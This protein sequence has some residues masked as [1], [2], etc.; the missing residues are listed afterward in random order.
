MTTNQERKDRK[1]ESILHMIAAG[2]T[3]AATIFA[4]VMSAAERGKWFSKFRRTE[5]ARACYW[6]DDR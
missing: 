1:L 3:R 4:A 2:T 5:A 6:T